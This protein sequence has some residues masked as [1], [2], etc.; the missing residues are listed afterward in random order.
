MSYNF[1]FTTKGLT[2]EKKLDLFER[3]DPIPIDTVCYKAGDFVSDTEQV[4]V[5]EVN[6]KE[7]TMFWNSLYFLDKDRADTVTCIAHA[8]YGTWLGECIGG[9]YD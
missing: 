4:T 2:L 6:Q 5:N 8:D 9:F 3:I 7:V 1:N